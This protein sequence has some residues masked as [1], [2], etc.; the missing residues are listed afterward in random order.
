MAY[1]RMQLHP[2]DSN[3]A[4]KHTLNCL[5]KG[6]VG[7]DF[8]DDIGNLRGE[9][10]TIDEKQKDYLKFED[11]MVP[12]DHILVISHHFPFALVEVSSDYVY[13]PNAKEDLGVWFRHLRFVKVCQFYADYCTNAKSWEVTK[14][15]DT[16]S[17]LR[18]VN[19]KSYRLIEDWVQFLK[20]TEI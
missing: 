10:G 8:F 19:S 1:W 17:P 13:V 16:I 5:S 20:S 15:T 7:F 14:M 2:G 11:E 9:H 18:D 4:S 12:G 3:N 6:I